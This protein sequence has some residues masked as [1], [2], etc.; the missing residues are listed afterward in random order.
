MELTVNGE[1]D[2]T[3]KDL[4]MNMKLQLATDNGS[5]G[6]LANTAHLLAFNK[7]YP[8]NDP[9]K[10]L[11]K[12]YWLEIDGMVVLVDALRRA[13]EGTSLQMNLASAIWCFGE[14]EQLSLESVKA[15]AVSV[16]IKLLKSSN[17][18]VSQ[19]G[20]GMI[21]GFIVHE[22][23][24]DMMVDE[25]VIDVFADL[26]LKFNDFSL[27]NGDASRLM[28]TIQS[29]INNYNCRGRLLKIVPY[30]VEI[31]SKISYYNTTNAAQLAA[32]NHSGAVL[33]ALATDDRIYTVVSEQQISKALTRAM[34]KLYAEDLASAEQGLSY[35]WTYFNRFLQLFESSNVLVRRY[36]AFSMSYLTILEVNRTKIINQGL[37]G[38]IQMLTFSKDAKTRKFAQSSMKRFDQPFVASLQTFAY[39][40][41]LEK[42]GADGCRQ[43]IAQCNITVQ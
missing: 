26:V 36:C 33:A 18:Q 22:E 32:M 21:M 12:K 1:L 16:A 34:K 17:E 35:V 6:E 7:F 14:S 15:G 4:L 19:K 25:G 9:V 20:I 38:R 10:R 5:E 27:E 2:Q 23:L 24:M 11:I 8:W 43:I 30:L 3:E 31:L 39:W 41:L 42:E 29:T 28:A 13:P 37:L 40:K